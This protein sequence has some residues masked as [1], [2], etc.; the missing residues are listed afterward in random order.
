M[1]RVSMRAGK[2]QSELR[3]KLVYHAREVR[4]ARAGSGVVGQSPIT[5]LIRSWQL[6]PRH[7][8]SKDY[9]RVADHP[10][11]M[12]VRANRNAAGYQ[13]STHS[14]YSSLSTAFR[15]ALT[16]VLAAWAAAGS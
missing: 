11:A 12:R 14:D 9:F 2:Q 4:R 7:L 1:Q 6:L 10:G 15:N 13:A 8:G 16:D 3:E 5:W